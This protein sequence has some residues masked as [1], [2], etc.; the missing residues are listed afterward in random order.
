MRAYIEAVVDD[1]GGSA[2]V[3]KADITPSVV[4]CLVRSQFPEWARLPV[5]AVGQDGWDNTTYRLGAE[6]SVRL[7]SGESYVAQVEKEHRWLP[8]LVEHLPLPVPQPLAMGAPGCGFPWPWSVYRWL[9][10]EPATVDNVGDRSEFARSLGRFLNALYA[11]PPA[12]GPMPGRHNFFRGASLETY[13]AE[14]RQAVALLVEDI[15]ADATIA[16]WEASLSASWQGEPVWFHGDVTGAN[17]LVEDGRLS[18]VI[19]F[20]TTGVGDPACDLT[21]AWTFFDGASRE[22]FCETIGCD[23]QTWARGRG[24]ALWK[25]LITHANAV[26]GGP[27]AARV[28]ENRFGWRHNARGI[29]EAVVADYEASEA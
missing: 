15:D 16:V 27:T 14:T 1:G 20:G 10:G 2:T 22:A 28:A 13:D 18:A 29:I 8:Y 9:P 24:W 26:Q 21:V 4:E 19:D 12:G 6:M 3:E 17:L 23:E 7:P 5:T 11:V 25:A